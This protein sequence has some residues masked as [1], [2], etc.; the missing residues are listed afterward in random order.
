MEPTSFS[1][2][3]HWTIRRDPNLTACVFAFWETREDYDL[4]MEKIHDKIFSDSLSHCK[5]NQ[6]PG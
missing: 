4:F 5:I 1:E 2:W 3:I 6:L